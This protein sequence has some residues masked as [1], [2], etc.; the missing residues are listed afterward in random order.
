MSQIANSTKAVDLIIVLQGRKYLCHL[1]MNI[2]EYDWNI[3]LNEEE[4]NTL[5]EWHDKL[6]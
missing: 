2:E 1:V 5:N 4:M 3:C 6:K